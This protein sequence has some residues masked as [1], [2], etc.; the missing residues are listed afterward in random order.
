MAFPAT[1]S[2]PSYG[3]QTGRVWELADQLSRQLGRKAKRQEVMDAYARE[4]GNTNTAS[5]QYSQWN[6]TTEVAPQAGATALDVPPTQ[7]EIGRD[8]RVLL[9]LNIRS[10]MRL[11]E[12]T[13]LTA[14]VQDG[15]LTLMSSRTA[16]SKLR[17]LIKS[18]DTGKG[19]V[20]DELIAERRAENSK[21]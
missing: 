21:G 13:T 20:V 1:T 6:K 8:G 15:V 2:R 5:T 17:H 19:S 3:T 7:L 18:T 14:E 4:G 16:V 10:A 11:G 9:P 12:S